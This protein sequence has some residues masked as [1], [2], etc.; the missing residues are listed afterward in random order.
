[1]QEIG[2][3]LF[4]SKK[5]CLFKTVTFF[6]SGRRHSKKQPKNGYLFVA[7]QGAGRSCAVHGARDTGPSMACVIK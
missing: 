4:L 6:I 1:M 2:L 3:F 7:A 5:H